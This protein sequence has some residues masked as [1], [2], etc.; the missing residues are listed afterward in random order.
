MPPLTPSCRI[1]NDGALP[2][3]PMRFT[4]GL[5]NLSALSAA[6][7]ACVSVECGEAFTLSL[8]FPRDPEAHQPFG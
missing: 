2:T 5:A 3:A 6:Q 8:S 7:G 1:T 4:G